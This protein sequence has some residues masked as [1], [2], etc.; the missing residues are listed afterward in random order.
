MGAGGS[1]DTGVG[2]FVPPIFMLGIFEL[3]AG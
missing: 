2:D 1:D 3:I